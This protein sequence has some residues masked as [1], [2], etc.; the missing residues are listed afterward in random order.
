MRSQRDEMDTH[1]KAPVAKR[2]TGRQGGRGL[3]GLEPL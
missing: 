3:E 1:D 2:E